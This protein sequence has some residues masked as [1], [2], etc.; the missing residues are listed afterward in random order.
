[1]NSLSSKKG[2]HSDSR[3]ASFYSWTFSSLNVFCL[4]TAPQSTKYM[5]EK[6]KCA[7]SW[8]FL[9][10]YFFFLFHFL[11]DKKIYL[12]WHLKG[13]VL[14]NSLGRKKYFG[15]FFWAGY[16]FSMFPIYLHI[17]YFAGNGIEFIVWASSK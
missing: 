9:A 8:T 13:D 10:S 17:S 11:K 3:T 2:T 14:S 1:M 15:Y 4:T 6:E 12:A 16:D 7:H 5:Y